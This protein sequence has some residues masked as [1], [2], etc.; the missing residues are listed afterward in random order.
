MVIVSGGTNIRIH[1]NVKGEERNLA[2][3]AT[4]IVGQ[5]FSQISSDK[6]LRGH[7][8]EAKEKKSKIKEIAFYTTSF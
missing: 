2:T 4:R 6:R 7:N 1:R 3:P 5:V 8:A